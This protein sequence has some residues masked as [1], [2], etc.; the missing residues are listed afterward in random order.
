MIPGVSFGTQQFTA[1]TTPA[2]PQLQ[3]PGAVTAL[4]GEVYTA[5]AAATR[6][7]VFATP[8]CSA[9]RPWGIRR[10][11]FHSGDPAPSRVAKG[12]RLSVVPRQ[13]RWM[14][15]FATQLTLTTTSTDIVRRVSP[16]A[17]KFLKCLRLYNR[18]HLYASFLYKQSNRNEM[19]NY[20]DVSIRPVFSVSIE[21]F[22]CSRLFSF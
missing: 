3:N 4:T 21:K 12:A 2:T 8:V 1:S 17:V 9:C 5:P 13:M 22:I 20:R 6:S 14:D 7:I 15:M 10:S 11:Y 19:R 16:A 18:Y